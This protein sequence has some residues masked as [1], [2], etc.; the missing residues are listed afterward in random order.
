MTIKIEELLPVENSLSDIQRE[1]LAR[2][3]LKDKDRLA[4]FH[5]GEMLGDFVKQ[6]VT[7]E[8]IAYELKDIG[9]HL[10]RDKEALEQFLEFYEDR[11][12]TFKRMNIDYSAY[13]PR[14]KTIKDQY[15]AMRKGVP[16]HA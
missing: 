7:A 2:L 4:M 16:S 10:K 8:R 12:N 6:I 5:L 11:I 1:F 13:E 3:S 9:S 14:V 15:A